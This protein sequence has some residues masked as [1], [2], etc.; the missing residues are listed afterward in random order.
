[1][2]Q[3]S[4]WRR[5]V[6]HFTHLSLGEHC[7][8]CPLSV[9]Q[10]VESCPPLLRILP[11]SLP[12][13]SLASLSPPF[14]SLAKEEKG[15]FPCPI[16]IPRPPSL[17]LS[18]ALLLLTRGRREGSGER[19]KLSGPPC[20]PFAPQRKDEGFRYLHNYGMWQQQN[21]I[22]SAA[23]VSGRR[24]LC[25]ALGGLRGPTLAK[26][27]L[28]F[29]AWRSTFLSIIAGGG[30]SSSNDSRRIPEGRLAAR[31]RSGGLDRQG[32]TVVCLRFSPS[33]FLRANFLL[34]QEGSHTVALSQGVH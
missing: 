21:L 27:S 3:T 15:C 12:P 18:P 5:G 10:I 2:C 20:A 16:S 23:A 13:S 19:H 1:M 17:S 8:A 34:L 6:V 32:K 22:F 26:G 14:G 31:R 33:S 24:G 7:L 29:L 25:F 28:F 9:L 11:F 30:S 4:S